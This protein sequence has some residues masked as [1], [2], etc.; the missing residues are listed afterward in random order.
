MRLARPTR[1]RPKAE[2]PRRTVDSDGVVT[3]ELRP[4]ARG[5]G[6]VAAIALFALTLVVGGLLWLRR[7]PAGTRL[8]EGRTA[9]SAA[10]AAN[11]PSRASLP[12][13][14]ARDRTS[15][16]D[17]LAAN[18]P[19]G[20]AP[21]DEEPADPTD[22]AGE[23]REGLAEATTTPPT[24]GGFPA[25]GTKR[26]KRGIVVP[27]DFKLPPG[28][29]R[30]YQS[31]DKGRMLEAILM[32]HPDYQPLDAQGKPLALPPDRVVPPSMA[33]P[34]LPLEMLNV[35]KDAYAERQEPPPPGF[36]EGD[37]DA[38]SSHR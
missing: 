37:D 31:T 1:P 4:G 26:I 35:P 19:Q 2:S 32:F 5:P 8:A 15:P 25:P 17:A 30:H 36:G 16:D 11:A 7:A 14:A 22:E 18:A 38:S 20:S 29:V 3:V 28:Y 9:R 24:I 23:T 33:P 13:N 34:G 10:P 6:R 27:E 12:M 21:T